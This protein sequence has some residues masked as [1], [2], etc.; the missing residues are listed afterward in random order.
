MR[1][2]VLNRNKEGKKE[3]E[4]KMF[5]QG[6]LG[7]AQEPCRQRTVTSIMVMQSLPISQ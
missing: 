5:V 3:G 7:E 2:A 1:E 4:V 6:C